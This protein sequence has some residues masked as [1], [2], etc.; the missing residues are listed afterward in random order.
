[1]IVLD[2]R[3]CGAFK[4]ILGEDFAKNPAREHEAHA[5]QLK[6][7]RQ[8]IKAKHADLEVETG[9]MSLDGKVEMI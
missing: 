2:H 7:L 9:L 8:Q 1:V 6:T 3:D 4:V 5:A